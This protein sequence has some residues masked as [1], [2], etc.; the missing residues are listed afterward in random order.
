MSEVTASLVK[1]L[2]D[3][4]G[5]GMMDCK[6]ALV[7]TNGNIEESIDWLRKKGISGA[8]KKSARVAADG[9]IAVSINTDAA[10]LVE[11]NSETDFVSRNPDFQKFAK[12]ISEIALI[13]GQTIDELKKA[14]YLDS[15]KTVEEALTD[16]IGLIGENIVLRRSSILMNTNNNIFSSYIHGQVNDGL[17]KIGVIL[18]LESNIASDK[19]ENLGKQIA[20]HIAASKP[21][22]ISSDDVDP[23][24]IERE[25]SILIEQAKDSGKP[26]NI[27]EKM[28][29]GR[30][31]KFFSEITLLDQTWVIDGE[32]KV[33]KIIKDLEKDLSCN[34]L[35]KDFKYFVLGEGIEVDKKDFATEVAEQIN[36]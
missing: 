3:K 27:I 17:G 20:M 14:K 26:D 25:R 24:V 12:N 9:V 36:N 11:I 23:E 22:A 19:I 2:R 35:I 16:L 4:T 8:E 30:I 5:A 15:D 10:A 34:I 18:S 29:D 6:N 21:M 28:V 31:S 32:S 13:H 7:E 1:E 33:S